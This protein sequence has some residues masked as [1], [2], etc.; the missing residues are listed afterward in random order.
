MGPIIR[1]NLSRSQPGPK[2]GDSRLMKM[3][4]SVSEAFWICSEIGILQA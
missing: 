2:S 1:L 4:I 3:M